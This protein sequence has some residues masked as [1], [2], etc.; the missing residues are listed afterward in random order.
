MLALLPS[1]QKQKAPARVIDVQHQF[2]NNN[3]ENQIA[4]FEDVHSF[5]PPTS[6]EV[7]SQSVLRRI[8]GGRSLYRIHC[9]AL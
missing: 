8:L 2:G 5:H 6:R 9:G 7:V 1:G 4:S 3:L